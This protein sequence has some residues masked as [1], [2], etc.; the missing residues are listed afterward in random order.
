MAILPDYTSGLISLANGS[1][2]V[3]GTGTMFTAAAF[4]AGDTLLIQNLIAVIASVDSNTKL[5]LAVPWTGTTITNAPYRAR[6][7][8]DGARVTARTTALIELLGNGV[9][10]SIAELPVQAGYVLVGNEAGGYSLVALADIGIDDP[11]GNLKSLATLN[12]AANLMSFFTGEGA[13]DLT[14]LTEFARTLLDDDNA[15]AALTT[16]GF[17]AFTRA[18]RLSTNTA[19][20]YSAL[21]TVPVA[22]IP[23][24]L[25]P[26]KA[27]RRGNILG[28][29]SQ[30]GGVPTGAIIERGSNANGE[31]VKFADGTQICW[32]ELNFAYTAANRMEQ[33]WSYPASFF[34]DIPSR[35]L[36]ITLPYQAASY[37]GLSPTVLLNPTTRPNLTGSGVLGIWGAGFVAGNQI[38]NVQVMVIGRWF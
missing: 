19:T 30:A 18:F 36:H 21:G 17:T 16:L 26:D 37:V 8:P 15:D 31:F 22:Q 27:F 14:P 11:K 29:V 9:L 35:S 2:T 12:S 5:T 1:V 38:N 3:T 34:G 20:A 7:L 6:Y 25:T 4:K 28:T 13:S 23:T 10:S 33:Q 24:T 32:A